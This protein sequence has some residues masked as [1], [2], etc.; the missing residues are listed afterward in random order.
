LV[1]V[2]RCCGGAWIDR[3]CTPSTGRVPG[4]TTTALG[5]LAAACLLVPGLWV[6]AAQAADAP[7][8][9][10]TPPVPM[11][12]VQVSVTIPSVALNVQVGAVAV[13]VS[14]V[15]VAVSVSTAAAAA[16]QQTTPN[17]APVHC[18]ES[19]APEVPPAQTAAR[20]SRAARASP[21]EQRALPPTRPA[22]SSVR[23]H[24]IRTPPVDRRPT[25]SLTATKLPRRV[26][27]RPAIRPKARR[28]CCEHARPPVVAVARRRAGPPAGVRLALDRGTGAA[29]RPPAPE[30]ESATDN[31]L[32][33]QLGVLAAFLYLVCLAGWYAATRPRRRRA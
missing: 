27:E 31:R 25:R 3:T 13:A 18:C 22:A 14:T 30:E 12:A 9:P 8:P 23:A 16:A 11:I 29:A 20:T 6:D 5:V 17:V 21:P 28:P 26:S 33:L 32:L 4:R 15:P 1:S 2:I 7:Q 10:V 24:T 19:A